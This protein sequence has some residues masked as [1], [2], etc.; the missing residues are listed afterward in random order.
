MVIVN[1]LSGRHALQI[2][3][4]IGNNNA[5]K[6]KSIADVELRTNLPAIVP[7]PLFWQVED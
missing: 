6:K 7:Q 3:E 2:I 4:G 1:F 5:V